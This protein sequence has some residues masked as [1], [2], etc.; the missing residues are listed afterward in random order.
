MDDSKQQNKPEKKFDGKIIASQF[1]EY[2]YKCWISD[3]NILVLE[4][5]IQP[6]SK[7]V[8][9]S[10]VYEGIDFVEILKTFQSEDLQFENCVCEL[11]DSGSRQIYILVHGVIKNSLVSKTFNQSFMIAYAGEHKK[12]SRKWTLMNSLLIIN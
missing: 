8:Y 7:L 1:I 12:N 5:I 4:E 6:Y 3:L 2:F 9:N 10:T 11:L